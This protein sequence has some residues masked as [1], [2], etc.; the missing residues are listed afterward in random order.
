MSV[1]KKKTLD[2]TPE[3]LVP[4]IEDYLVEIHASLWG[5]AY[6]IPESKDKALFFILDFIHDIAR[7]QEE[8][9]KK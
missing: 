2:L 6:E 8:R 7:M 3:A 5:R 9:T 1:P 4:V